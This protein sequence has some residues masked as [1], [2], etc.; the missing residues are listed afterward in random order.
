MSKRADHRARYI[1]GWNTLDAEKL[2]ASVSEDFRFDDP[3][4]PAPVTKAALADYLPRWHAKARA[5]G[6]RFAFEESDKVVQDRGGVL[7]EWYWWKL[8]GTAVEGSALIKTTDEG[9]VYERLAY[10]RAP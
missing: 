8:A 2:L 3:D 10:Y 7:L 5:L 1:E 4:D 6:G 9:V